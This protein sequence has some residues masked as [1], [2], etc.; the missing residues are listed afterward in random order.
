MLLALLL[1]MPLYI[2]PSV[3][4]TD[5]ASM[6]AQIAGLNL[7]LRLRE[8]RRPVWQKLALSIAMGTFIGLGASFKIT[9]VFIF[10]A[11]VMTAWL[12]SE[13]PKRVLNLYAWLL[14]SL[15]VILFSVIAPRVL[16]QRYV[17]AEQTDRYEVPLLNWVMMGLNENGLERM[18]WIG[19]EIGPDYSVTRQIE[20][21]DARKQHVID[22]IGRRAG[23]KS[24]LDFMRLYAKKLRV[25]Y[26]RVDMAPGA[27]IP[28]SGL[29]KDEGNPAFRAFLDTA[30]WHPVYLAWNGLIFYSAVIL[31]VASV[32]CKRR[33]VPSLLAFLGFNV[34]FLIWEVNSRQMT[35]I[36]FLILFMASISVHT[37]MKPKRGRQR[38]SQKAEELELSPR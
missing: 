22:E 33:N 27:L 37:L 11:I 5:V 7:Y 20:T 26:G 29:E 9:A 30:R 6:S 2:F 1:Y 24:F 31:A 35:N 14:I 15:V 34:F 10:I 17:T 21:M 12:P 4:Y 8:E 25:L 38:E 32:F 16:I 13:R 28:F 36:F 19:T 3:L 23:E 18:K